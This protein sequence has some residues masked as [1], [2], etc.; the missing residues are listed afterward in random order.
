[1][2]D[3]QRQLRD[4]RNRAIR[5]TAQ[6]RKGV[7]PRVIRQQRPRPTAKQLLSFLSA[8]AHG[9]YVPAD[10]ATAR[11]AI[12]RGCDHQRE[13]EQGRWCAACGCGTSAA[14]RKITNLAAYEENLPHWGCKHPERA[15]GRGWPLPAL[16]T[17]EAP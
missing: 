7:A 13:N 9:R 16:A 10:V 17:V 14:A 4:Q 11:D 1:M 12:C 8:A 3:E 5:L 2:T 6:G 15:E